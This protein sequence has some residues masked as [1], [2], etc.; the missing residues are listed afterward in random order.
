MIQIK[1][2][3]VLNASLSSVVVYLDNWAIGKLAEE[4]SS[5]RAR[6]ISATHSGADL[7]LSAANVA[8]LSGPKG[9]SAD[10][11]RSFLDELGPRWYPVELNTIEIVGRE[12]NGVQPPGAVC[13]SRDLLMDY[14]RFKVREYTPGSGKVIP[15][16]S[17]LFCLGGA[18]DWTGP[19]RDSIVKGSAELDAALRD[20][21]SRHI[22]KFR[23]EATHLD[24]YLPPLPFCASQPASF[25]Y[26]HLL[27][28][29]IREGANVNEH[30]GLDFSH[31][32][33]GA[34]FANFAAL[35]GRWKHLVETAPK[36]HTLASVYCASELDN[37]VT[38]LERAVLAKAS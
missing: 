6:F 15:F 26:R 36:P 3:G 7:L 35:D 12:Q 34:A 2:D 8:E 13:V 25:L 29:L 5:R 22:Q 9:R 19:Q 30:D 31:A 37:L 23:K 11:V 4:D 18:L 21:I 17:D 27:R 28:M 32:I 16:S 1:E 24:N 38:D 10:F 33:M 20:R 14:M